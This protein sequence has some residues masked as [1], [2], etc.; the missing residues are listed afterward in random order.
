[1]YV[2]IRIY[3]I[4]L[5]IIH[6]PIIYVCAVCVVSL[7]CAYN[8]QC[9]YTYIYI[10]IYIYIFYIY[11]IYIFKLSWW[12]PA[13]KNLLRLEAGYPALRCHILNKT[14]VTRTTHTTQEPP[15]HRTH[16]RNKM[17]YFGAR[18]HLTP[19]RLEKIPPGFGLVGIIIRNEFTRTFLAAAS[20]RPVARQP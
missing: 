9:V 5:H 19:Q 14:Q 12:H 11:I 6:T 7:K 2:K 16:E 17:P 15:H 8:I 3:S 18:T 13:S 4:I 20:K 1:M 10:Y